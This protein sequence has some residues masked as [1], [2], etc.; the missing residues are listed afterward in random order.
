MEKHSSV[1]VVRRYL[2]ERDLSEYSGVAVR[3]LQGWR[4]RG[5]GPPWVK[6]GTIVRYDIERFDEW[7][8]AHTDRRAA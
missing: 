2:S 7:V 3:T 6:M 8:V 5:Q 4:V 1:P